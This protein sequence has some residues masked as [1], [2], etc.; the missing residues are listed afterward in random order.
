M[1]TI[2]TQIGIPHEGSILINTG[3]L[4]H[5]TGTVPD[6]FVSD[7]YVSDGDDLYWLYAFTATAP[8]VFTFGIEERE[9]ETVIS[10]ESFSIT[11]TADVEDYD[12]CCTDTA[13]NIAWLNADGGWQNYIF[14]GKHQYKVETGV[15]TTFK[16]NDIVKYS[17]RKGV[18]DAVTAFSQYVPR[19]HIDYVASL[20]VGV[21]AFLYNADTEDWD[22]PILIQADPYLKYTDKKELYLLSVDF[23]YATEKIIQTQ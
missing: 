8:G 22:I 11:V 1:I 10:S 16:N 9:G 18:F 14:P 21:Q 20:K 7:G 13:M 23:I 2:N 17:E 6:W 19:H 3:S 5:F 12:I 15:A 4:V